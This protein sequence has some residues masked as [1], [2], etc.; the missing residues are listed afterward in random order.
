[1]YGLYVSALTFSLICKLTFCDSFCKSFGLTAHRPDPARWHRT[2]CGGPM[3]GNADIP[4][5]WA[6][7]VSA[8]ST[9]LS[10]YPRPQMV[11]GHGKNLS[12]LRDAG[13]PSLW[14]NLNGLWEWELAS[15]KVPHFNRP[16][17]EFIL[18]PFPAESCLSG[19]GQPITESKNMWYPLCL[20]TTPGQ[21]GPCFILELSI[22]GAKCI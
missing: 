4:T 16:L 19:T 10:Y 1:M 17:K 7:Q 14:C 15:S 12:E 6:Q 9:P 22:G 2:R 3:G 5:R 20:I 21:V 11:R 18:V 13:D 8:S